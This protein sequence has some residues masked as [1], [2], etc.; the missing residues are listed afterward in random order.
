MNSI[1]ETVNHYRVRCEGC[2]HFYQIALVGGFWRLLHAKV[3]PNQLQSP[4]LPTPKCRLMYD[5]VRFDPCNH[6]CPEV[7]ADCPEPHTDKPGRP[8]EDGCSA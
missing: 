3:D 7:F 4:Q 6:C 1:I 2:D 5:F 8:T